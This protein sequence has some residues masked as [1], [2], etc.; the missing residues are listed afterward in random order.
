MS[1]FEGKADMTLCGN[2]RLRSL[3]GVKRTWVGALHMSA[4]TQSGHA[5][6]K[7]YRSTVLVSGSDVYSIYSIDGPYD[8]R[9]LNCTYNVRG[10]TRS[11]V[12]LP[13]ATS[14]TKNNG[15]A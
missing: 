9:G 5:L 4:L 10:L 15:P 6:R 1:A 2:P 14:S 12:G 11:L 8:F 13:I 3:L 7:A